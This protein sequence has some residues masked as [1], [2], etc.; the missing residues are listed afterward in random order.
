MESY[1]LWWR[2]PLRRGEC[3]GLVGFHRFEKTTAA[4]KWMTSVTAGWLTETRSVWHPSRREQSKSD[5]K[6]LETR[7]TLNQ[8]CNHFIEIIV[9]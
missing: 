1:N 3:G 8:K 2:M 5:A 9:V 6:P 4:T 7:F